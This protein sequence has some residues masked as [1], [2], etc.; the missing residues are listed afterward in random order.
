MTPK[1]DAR[2]LPT[3]DEFDSWCQHPVTRFVAASYAKAADRQKAAWEG[4]FDKPMIPAD[5][6]ALRLEL[7]TREDAYRSILESTL[8]D[9]LAILDHA[10]RPNPLQAAQRRKAG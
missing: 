8:A 3:Q 4:Y 10:A 2:I 6:Q 7:K 1:P 5:I 9:Y